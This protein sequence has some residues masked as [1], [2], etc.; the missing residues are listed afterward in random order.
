MEAQILARNKSL[1]KAKF[2]LLKF[3]SRTVL[4]IIQAKADYQQT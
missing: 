2:V 3:G 1:V 4:S